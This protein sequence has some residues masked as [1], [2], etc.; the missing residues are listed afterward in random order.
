MNDALS[1]FA[2]WKT[3]FYLLGKVGYQERLVWQNPVSGS[4]LMADPLVY[5]QLLFDWTLGLNQYLALLKSTASLSDTE[6]PMRR[7]STP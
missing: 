1:L 2:D 4:L 5:D 6:V 7:S 3:D